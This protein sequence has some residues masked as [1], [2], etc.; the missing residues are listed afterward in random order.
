MIIP[1]A[2]YGAANFRNHV[3]PRF[4]FRVEF[5]DA[6][7][8]D[9]YIRSHADISIGA[10]NG[11]VLI[12]SRPKAIT[13]ISQRMSPREGTATIGKMTFSALD[14]DDEIT[15]YMRDQILN[16]SQGNRWRR[17]WYY[18]GYE[19]LSFSNYELLTTQIVN[20][21][22]FERGEYRFT[23]ADIQRAARETIF[24]PIE[25]QLSQPLD[26]S[27]TTIEIVTSSG[28]IPLQHDNAYT[29]APGQSVAYVRIDDE[30]I[31]VPAAGI[32]SSQLT[33]VSRGVL[34]TRAEE[35][36]TGSNG[37]AVTEV[38]YLEGPFTKLAYAALTGNL[39]GQGETLPDHWHA[40][41]P[42]S[43][44]RLADFL[45][46]G[47]DWFDPTDET[48]GLPLRFIEPNSSSA[49]A[50]I[51]KQICR[52]FSAFMPVYADGQLGFKRLQPIIDGAAPVGVIDD[53][54][55]VQP[56]ALKY[57]YSEI[58]NDLTIEWAKL[59]DEL[60]RKTRIVDQESIDRWQ[61][62]DAI[63]F[64][65]EGLHGSR[66]SAEQVASIIE[67]F[68]DR[69]SW[70][71]ITTQV[72]V[73]GNQNVFE[74]GDVIRLKTDTAVIF[75]DPQRATTKLDHAFEIQRV[76][77]DVLRG[78]VQLDLFASGS[79]AGPLP[80]DFAQ[81]VLPDA[82]ITQGTSIAALPGVTVSPTELTFTA[83]VTLTGQDSNR[84]AIYYADRDVVIP[85]GVTVS[86]T[87]NVLFRGTGSL[88]VLGEL[89][90]VAAGLAGTSDV[91]VVENIPEHD[92]DL[93]IVSN[94][95]ATTPGVPGFLGTTQAGG[96][97]I[98]RVNQIKDSTSKYAVQIQSVMATVTQ[99]AF[100]IMPSFYVEWDGS[101]LQGVPT[102]LR[103]SSGGA[104]GYRY[105]SDEDD[106]GNE[107]NRGGDGGAGG[108][109]LVLIFRG[110]S[111]GA[112]GQLN[113]SGGPGSVGTIDS[114]HE[115]PAWG[116]SGAGGAPGGTLCLIDGP[117]NPIPVKF[118]NVI[119][120][121]GDSPDPAEGTFSRPN[122]A[123]V[124]YASTRFENPQVN[125]AFLQP[126]RI[127]YFESAS[128]GVQVGSSAFR[129]ILIMPEPSG[130][131][132]QTSEQIADEQELSLA[133]TEAYDD[134]D[135]PRVTLLRATV[136]EVSTT[137]SYG[138]AAIYYRH[139]GAVGWQRAGFAEPTLD[140]ELPADGETYEVEARAVLVNGVESG[141]SAAQTAIVT[142][143]GVL[144]AAPDSLT[145]KP[146]GDGATIKVGVPNT[147]GKPD[148]VNIYRSTSAA[149]ASPTLIDSVPAFYVLSQD[150]FCANY[151][152]GNLQGATPQYYWATAVNEQGETARYPAG[153][154]RE[155][156]P[157]DA[158]GGQ[159]GTPGADAVA[160]SNNRFEWRYDG[161]GW[162]AAPTITI[163]AIF[164][165]GALTNI[166]LHRLSV[167]RDND[168][169][170]TNVVTATTTG[171]AT[172]LIS[173]TG[174]NTPTLRAI[175]E[176]TASGVRS[177]IIV[178]SIIDGE[179]AVTAVGFDSGWVRDADGAFTPSGTTL[180]SPVRF[181]RNGAEVAARFFRGTRTAAGNVNSIQSIGS[182]GESTSFS[183]LGPLDTS[184]A[185]VS[186]THTESGAVAYGIYSVAI[187]GADGADAE[188]VI[189]AEASV[190]NGIVRADGSGAQIS[191]AGTSGNISVYEGNSLVNLNLV[192]FSVIGTNP[193]NGITASVNQS[194]QYSFAGTMS[195]DTLGFTFRATY[196]GR[197]ADVRVTLTK[198]RDGTQG[199]AGADSVEAYAN[200]NLQ[201]GVFGNV[202]ITAN[203]T[204]SGS[205]NDGEIW[206]SA[207]TVFARGGTAIKLATDQVVLTNY[208]GSGNITDAFYL[209]ISGQLASERFGGQFSAS[210]A[211]VA[212]FRS[213]Q[214]VA[215]GNDGVPVSFTPS[216]NDS[217]IGVGSRPSTASPGITTLASL[218]MPAILN[219][220][221]AP[222]FIANAAINNAMI[223]SVV[224]NK[225]AAGSI[226]AAI[227]ISTGQLQ[228]T[229]QGKIFAGKSTYG[230]TAQGFFLGYDGGVPKFNIGSANDETYMRFDGS[231]LILSSPIIIDGINNIDA[232]ACRNA[233]LFAYGQGD[234]GTVTTTI[235]FG[236]DGLIRNIF[237]PGVATPGQ[238]AYV[239][240]YIK[241][242]ADPADYDVELRPSSGT[243]D[244]GA[245]NTRL[246]L[247]ADRE[248]GVQ[249][250]YPPETARSCSGEVLFYHRA[251]DQ[252]VAQDVF[253]ITAQTVF[254]GGN[255]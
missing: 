124:Q 246:R 237:A 81:T 219:S 247:N 85:Q 168:G 16:S 56:P 212:E 204:S 10:I 25:L 51:E 213:G 136:T 54:V 127:S 140:F 120:D 121:Y 177:V 174:L 188:D 187:E 196:N 8:D 242:G 129:S 78:R 244:I 182:S 210:N 79:D 77:Y 5:S 47:E 194:G 12:A 203:S 141:L 99:G 243:L 131:E 190:P 229:G 65:A 19:G 117:L 180:D 201:F 175:V 207:G 122:E 184:R 71:P 153:N 208:E 82:W 164:G 189:R 72:T 222:Q 134:R 75:T 144:P 179:S 133:V 195:G 155:V 31:R 116:G 53:S 35:H 160:A 217:V 239:H 166:A 18:H 161:T 251:S 104:G 199:D 7:T 52:V 1:N 173:T 145:T 227:Q 245:A 3:E 91:A 15:D 233:N 105:W 100:D 158:T 106:P 236:A 55:L 215:L 70:P 68:R 126:D 128:A 11:T 102:D 149:D 220:E 183:V 29:D 80:A 193:L 255:G 253:Q 46:I 13:A 9:L 151:T 21:I 67:R 240:Q 223:D 205:P 241:N 232:I 206:L 62:S 111:F 20:G 152:D 224:A 89:N 42:A 197:T 192:S 181:F 238:G 43:L 130:V 150:E 33:G 228:L 226:T 119:A 57:E 50:F 97:L 123:F 250:S 83:D 37:K 138:T 249:Q 87:Q 221:T 163:D 225:I 49:K 162:S 231:N 167:S 94:P 132:D 69:Y 157:S 172:S 103:G 27:S 66:Y 40:G 73:L 185:L 147:L 88:T 96:A 108:A 4:V 98:E 74:V 143:S 58:V 61:K 178:T 2:A 86:Y 30:I 216:A 156:I 22:S 36:D 176:H 125:Q 39:I 107:I 214:W 191:L 169:N 252:L 32:L 135:D 60:R 90:G 113:S 38:V 114:S 230:S 234:S 146:V 148:T 137:S 118:G 218:I 110:M 159:P 14:I 92:T 84:D 202:A 165:R 142:D 211:F 139:L 198:V 209:I 76:R 17:V 154:G 200:S 48:R 26:E 171:E 63:T 28:L 186:V 59:G 248:F 170:I 64:E 41:I 235:T 34:G 44:I 109:G 23:C 24:E 45:A 95:P 115:R 93:Q 254:I 112:S 6:A 101:D